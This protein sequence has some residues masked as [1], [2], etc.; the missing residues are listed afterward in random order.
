MR[1]DLRSRVAALV[2]VSFVLAW[3]CMAPAP[4]QAAPAASATE[5]RVA[6][7]ACALLDQPKTRGKMDGR[8]LML[9]RACG[10]AS[11]LGQVRNE[12]VPGR[13]G[14]G[15]SNPDVQVNDSGDDLAGSHTQSETS[16]AHNPV[17]GTLCSGFNDSYSG[18]EEGLGYTGFSRSTD[19]GA[20]WDD[21]GALGSN[22]FGDPS[23]VWRKTDGNFYFAA[24]E[25]GGLG[26]W[27]STDDCLSFTF[28]GNTHSGFGDDKEI[29]TVDNNPASPYYGRLYVAWTDFAAGGQIFINSSSDGGTT[30]STAVALSGGGDDVQGAWPTVAPNG[31]VFVGWL[32]W[33]PFP[34]GPI[35]VQVSRSVDGG[36]SFTLVT[37]PM[38]GQVNPRAAVA[39]GNCGRPA[40]NGNVRILP[41]PQVAVTPDGTLHAVYNYDPDGFDTGDVANVYY[42]RSLDNGATW[43]TEVLLNDDGTTRD[44]WQPS[45]SVGETGIVSAA[46]YDRRLDAGN[47]LY[48]TYQAVSQDVGATFNANLRL[49]DVSSP[50][51]LDPELATCYHSDYDS[52]LQTATTIQLLWSDDRN[53]QDGHPDPDVFTEAV[54]AGIDFL[55]LASPREV[56]VCAPADA[57]YQIEVPQFQGFTEMV[58]LATAGEPAGTSAA[59]TVNPVTP[60]GTSE[61]TL[62]GTGSLAAGT[63]DF[64]IVGTSIPTA[65]VHD[66]G[67]TLEVFTAAP[68][69]VTLTSPADGAI[70]QI[71][72]P[73]LAWAATAQASS[74]DLEVATD[75][76]FTSI[77][78]SASVTSLS[79]T[80]GV[81]LTSETL[82]YWHVRGSNLC[83]DGTYSGAFTFTTRAIPPYLLV[84]DDDNAT[85]V[86]PTYEAAMNALGK[87]FDVWSTNISDN[88]PNDLELTAYHTV[89]WFTGHHFGGACGPGPASETALATWLDS[90]GRCLIMV[91]QDYHFDRGTTPFMVSHLGIGVVT[92][93]TGQDVVTGFAGGVFDGLGPYS[94]SYPFTNFSDTVTPSAGVSTTTFTG[95]AGSASIRKAVAAYRTHFIVFPWEAIS[96]EADRVAV[97]D[98]LLDDCADVTNVIFDDGFETGDTSEWTLVF[99]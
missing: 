82:Y 70:D 21:R 3:L 28:L 49:S 88:E 65:I 48:D 33:N 32:R 6:A 42:R 53:I 35:D 39:T 40:V 58:T 1:R 94:L 76:A 90:G 74:Y 4:A 83:G 57:V 79:H 50:V 17:T 26:V 73:T 54:P 96:L 8:L 14:S 75:A 29:M 87:P 69:A 67:V 24:L 15:P 11:E 44:Q 77:I 30:W 72:V 95:D 68:G 86:L 37:N 18:V 34:S 62:S 78:Y 2:G 64:D 46:W 99:P 61:L 36:A 19:G 59:F 91:S 55:V 31:D 23:L 7:E 93:D 38:T 45:L 41:S 92:D 85:N 84:D 9:L 25:S 66:V 52:Q 10:R 56:E 5:Q 89:I 27:R 98:R 60:P 43:E 97:L 16:I 81:A 51:F 63:Y 47:L 13:P 71:L 22:S 12:E 80:L 20:T